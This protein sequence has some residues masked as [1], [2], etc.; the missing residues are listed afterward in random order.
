MDIDALR[1]SISGDIG[2]DLH[3]LP[4]VGSTNR[5]LRDR[6][7]G[8]IKHGT[9][10]VTDYQSQ[11]RGRQ[12]RI[13]HAPSGSSLLL[14]IALAWPPDIALAQ[15]VMMAALAAKDALRRETGLQFELKWPNDL[16]LNGKK[17]CGILAESGNYMSPGF[18]IVGIGVNCN[19]DVAEIPVVL[20]GATTLQTESGRPVE[21]ERLA[22]ELFRQLEVWYRSLNEYPDMVF[23]AWSSCLDLEDQIVV[24]ED[25]S[26]VWEAVVTALQP[27][28]ALRVRKH[29]GETRLVYAANVSVRKQPRG[30]TTP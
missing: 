13:W 25:A 8:S 26:G 21:R 1:R 6:P 18:I 24:I 28:G 12:G 9:A 7:I 23:T 14:S 29:N 15:S 2:A 22:A 4:E 17:V 19:F 20:A 11:G 16:L 27:D 5:W 3:Y 30:F 10:I